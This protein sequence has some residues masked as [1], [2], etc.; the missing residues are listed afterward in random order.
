MS[1]QVKIVLK[2]GKDQSIKRYHPWIFSGAIKK[3]YGEPAEGDIVHVYSNQDEFL[4]S[5]HFQDSSIAI[6]ILSFK[7]KEL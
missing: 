7:E 3:T 4:G 2:S 5:G 6:R 1:E